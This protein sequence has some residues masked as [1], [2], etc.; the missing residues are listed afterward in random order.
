MEIRILPVKRARPGLRV[1]VA[2]RETV[3]VGEAFPLP[4]RSRDTADEAID[5]IE[6]LTGRLP[7]IRGTAREV[8]SVLAE[9][10]DPERYPSAAFALESAFLDFV[11]HLSGRPAWA[12]LGGHPGTRVPLNAVVPVGA[13]E[14]RVQVAIAAIDAGFSAVKVK[15]GGQDVASDV[16]VLRYIRAARPEAVLRVDPN[17]GWSL[18]QARGLLESLAPLGLEYAEQP[19]SPRDLLALDPIVPLAADESMEDRA[20]RGAVLESERIAVVVLKPALVGGIT[21]TLEI[22]AAARARGKRVVVTHAFDGPVAQAAA[23]EVALALGCE[24]ACGLHLHG[25]L[26]QRLDGTSVRASNAPGLG[27][28]HRRD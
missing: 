2:T 14:T 28:A 18:P 24:L 17:M 1:L 22:G 7:R 9:T 8:L 15:F 27:L 13:T 21:R 16:E 4:G 19:V 26:S 12:L 20:F 23:I 25:G 6:R 3:G 10:V 5:V 11:G